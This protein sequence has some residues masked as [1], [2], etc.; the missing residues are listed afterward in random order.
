MIQIEAGL[1]PVPFTFGRRRKR[2]AGASK[3]VDGATQNHWPTVHSSIEYAEAGGVIACG[4]DYAENCRSSAAYVD[5]IFKDAKPF[6]QPTR[7]RGTTQRTVGPSGSPPA[8]GGGTRDLTPLALPPNR[9]TLHAY[10]AS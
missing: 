3:R 9:V 5:K 2:R 1:V 8:Q 10:V 7:S 4:A 6:A